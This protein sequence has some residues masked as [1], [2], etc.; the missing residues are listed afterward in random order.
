MKKLLFIFVLAMLAFTQLFA[1][2]GLPTGYVSIY[3]LKPDTELMPL[4][5]AVGTAPQLLGPANGW[6]SELTYKLSNYEKLAFKFTYNAADAGKQV[7]VRF[8]I[9]G[10]AVAQ[11][12]TFPV[13]STSFVYEVDIN[14]LKNT[15]GVANMGGIVMYNAASHWSLTWTAADYCANPVVVDYIALKTIPATAVQVVPLDATQA[16]ALP[17]NQSTTLKAEFTPANATYQAVTWQSANENIATVSNTGVVTSKSLAGPVQITATSVSNPALSANFTV[18]VVEAA[19]P[20]SGVQLPATSEVKI[21]KEK[22]LQATV[23]PSNATN[24]TLTWQSSDPTVASVDATGKVTG[25]K[26]GV[27][28]ITATTEDGN[29]SAVSELTVYNYAQIPSNY[30]SIYTLNY[31]MEGTNVALSSTTTFPS[32]VVPAVFTSDANSLLGDAWNWNMAT[33]YVDLSQFSEVA[34]AVEFKPEDVGKSFEFRYAFSSATGSVI[35]NRMYTI[36]QLKDVIV[37]DLLNDP[38]DTDKLKRLGAIKTRNASSGVVSFDVDY[39]AVRNVATSI[40]KPVLDADAL[41][42]VY[43]INGQL[44]RRSVKMGEATIGLARGL[45]IINNS[46]VFVTK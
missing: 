13:E 16:N 34:V 46:K 31:N 2:L 40:E 24:K 29:F 22:T 21:T 38:A 43:N 11:Y 33:K 19:T 9:N 36:S 17:F 5:V 1:S 42:N 30:V 27:T 12:V 28:N 25:L 7:V 26:V 41:V 10:A 18:T 23:L 35:T 39:V 20:V 4:S 14:T 44:V 8:S 32:A 15:S 3:T 37:I 6:G 45:Y